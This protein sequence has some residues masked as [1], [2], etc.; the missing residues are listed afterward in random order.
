MR[1]ST[2]GSSV[3]LI[4]N[5]MHFC[6]LKIFITQCLAK[7]ISIKCQMLPNEFCHFSEALIANGYAT[8]RL[9]YDNNLT[10]N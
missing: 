5:L 10:A 7:I 9:C 6:N 2:S 4:S 3:S 8:T 1:S